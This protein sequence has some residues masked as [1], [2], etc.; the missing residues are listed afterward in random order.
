MVDNQWRDFSQ[1]QL[2]SD[3]TNGFNNS[4]I[5]CLELP[6]DMNKNM[7]ILTSDMHWIRVTLR[8]DASLM[9]K[10]RKVATQ[11]VSCTWV[12]NGTGA[13]HLVKP[14]PADSIKKL[15]SSIN[16][17][18]RVNQPFPSFGGR[19]GEDKTQFYVRTSERL[20]HKNRAVSAWDYERLVL[21]KFPNIHQVK[22]VTHVGNESYVDAGSVSVVVIPKINKAS[23]NITFQWSTR[24]F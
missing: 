10:C 5:I 2:L 23:L 24:L 16:Q 11:A 22:C 19:V 15:Q 7:D 4:G 12:D 3:G 20:R 9:P 14:L 13:S 6:K 18:R 8:G 17:I 1:N 21:D